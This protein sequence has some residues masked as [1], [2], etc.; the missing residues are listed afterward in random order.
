MAEM[1]IQQ[2]FFVSGQM[3]AT[4]AEAQ[5]FV[6]KPKVMK[7]LLKLT[8]NREDLAEFLYEKR[9]ILEDTFNVGTITR[10]TKSEKRQLKEALDY[11]EA[12]FKED[13]I[14]H[15]KAKF[16]ADNAGAIYEVFRWPTVKRMKDEEKDAAIRTTLGGLC[17]DNQDL[18]NWIIGSKDKI[19]EAFEAGVE[20][21]EVDPKATAGLAKY[22]EKI[23]LQ[24]QLKEAGVEFPEDAD[25]DALKELV[26][27]L[28]E[29]EVSEEQ[30]T[31]EVQQKIGRAH[32]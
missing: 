25:N 30:T 5:E 21:R 12:L 23:A 1:T 22:R 14:A 27:Q 6:R 32:V 3:F 29:P 15:K 13:P 4:K 18:V 17:G 24:K 16:V 31:E 2:G 20:K 9:E 10:V 19:F 8:G 26:A 11:I 28:P 7:E